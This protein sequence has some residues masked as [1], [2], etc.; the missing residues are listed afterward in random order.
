MLDAARVL[1]LFG[2]GCVT[3]QT[4]LPAR[5]KTHFPCGSARNPVKFC[6]VKFPRSSGLLLHPTSLPSRFGIGD[7]GPC[8]Y[9]FV[10]FLAASGQ[11]LWQ[12]LPLNPTGYGD[13]PYQC[14][15]AFAGNPLLISLEE[16]QGSG[17][18]EP[19]DLEN[20]PVFPAGEVDYAQ[21]IEFKL[22]VLRQAAMRF[23]AAASQQARSTFDGF[24]RKH[25]SWLDDYAL[26]M[27]AKQAH[28]VPV[29]TGWPKTLRDREPT[30][31][32]QFVTR[33]AAQIQV[34]KYWQFEFFRQWD[35]LKGYCHERS[36][37]V[38]G[39]LPIYAAH[40]SADVW[41]NQHLFQLDSEGRPCKIA[42]VPPDYFSAVGQ[43][44]G[45]PV[46][47]WDVLRALEYGWWV[48]RVRGS[49][50]LF[51]LVRLDHFRGFEA[52]WVVPAGEPNAVNGRW[53]KGPGAELFRALQ[54]ELGELPLVAENLGAHSARLSARNY[55]PDA[56][57]S[58][59][60]G[61]PEAATPPARCHP[62]PSFYI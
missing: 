28:D 15:S 49:L 3:S 59:R 61:I 40:D 33:F 36:I 17:L 20:T 56:T 22:A 23:F 2:I 48:A 29:W 1:H 45:N 51:D 24:C 4:L 27:A 44:W 14:F 26:F 32:A 52:Y 19:S 7:L 47:R 13:S 42:G 41:A 37:R 38:M 21:V 16:L 8:A 50:R 10:D 25:A 46:Y 62:P 55:S 43:L 58:G 34:F 6:C 57:V 60:R 54:A 18:L 53:V 39:D 5:P 31:V 12:V 9:E 11:K 30:A 35:A